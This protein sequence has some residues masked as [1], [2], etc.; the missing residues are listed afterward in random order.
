MELDIDLKEIFLLQSLEISIGFKKILTH[1][2]HAMDPSNQNAFFRLC[3]ENFTKGRFS[4]FINLWNQESN[5]EVICSTW[6]G[7]KV[8][9]MFLI[10]DTRIRESLNF[11]SRRKISLSVHTGKHPE[12][13]SELRFVFPWGGSMPT[14][15]L[16]SFHA[17]CLFTQHDK[18]ALWLLLTQVFIVSKAEYIFTYCII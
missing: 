1:R 3:R 5:I 11:Y 2:T 8:F 13:R 10:Q 7:E 12:D 16:M 9:F 4:A 14:A 15:S 18:W 17:V 6:I